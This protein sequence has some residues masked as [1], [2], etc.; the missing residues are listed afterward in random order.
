MGVAAVEHEVRSAAPG[1][2]TRSVPASTSSEASPS[3]AGSFRSNVTP[4]RR[5]GSA[6]DASTASRSVPRRSPSRS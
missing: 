2:A 4:T 5:N 1:P 6:F 3:V